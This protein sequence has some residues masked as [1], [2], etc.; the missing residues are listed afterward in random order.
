MVGRT[1][2]EAAGVIDKFGQH[3]ADTGSA[4]VQ[5]SL[6]SARVN[7]L[8]E[9]LRVHKHDHHTRQGLY[10]VLGQRRKLCRYLRDSDIE[11][12]RD[13]LLTLN[14]RDPLGSS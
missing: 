3:S 13:L 11:A 8:T 5:I 1:A 10:K 7:H 2:N 12:Y 4:A 6:L 9:H 14:I